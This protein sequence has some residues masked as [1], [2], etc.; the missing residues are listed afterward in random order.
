MI[1]CKEI[2]SC[3]YGFPL[4]QGEDGEGQYACRENAL[5]GFGSSC[6][7]D[8]ECESGMCAKGGGEATGICIKGCGGLMLSGLYVC[9]WGGACISNVGEFQCLPLC[10]KGNVQCEAGFDCQSEFLGLPFEMDVCMPQ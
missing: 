9:P 1:T 8:S 5:G 10:P 4:N 7:T 6:G 3:E 2:G